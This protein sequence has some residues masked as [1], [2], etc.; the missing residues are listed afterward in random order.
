MLSDIKHHVGSKIRLYRERGKLS[1][2]TLGLDVGLTK[3]AIWLIERG[4]SWPEFQNLVAIAQR[5]GVKVEA[6]FAGV[7]HAPISPTPEEA[8]AVLSEIVQARKA[9]A[10]IGGLDAPSKELLEAFQRAD[11]TLKELILALLDVK[12]LSDDKQGSGSGQAGSPLKGP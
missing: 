10:R 11:E 2:E 9:P 1:Q 3:Q 4:D 8:L 7:D 12:Y 6:F 5:L